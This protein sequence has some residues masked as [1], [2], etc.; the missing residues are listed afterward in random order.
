[1]R[2]S[3]SKDLSKV[4]AC[5]LLCG[6]AIAQEAVPRLEPA[7]CPFEGADGRDDVQCSY[8]VVPEN[9][10]APAGKILRL[11]VAVLKSTN[12]E[13][14]PD[15]LVFLSG[16][17]GGPSVRNSIARLNSPFWNRYRA[18]RDLVF[19]DQR[20]T[21]FSEPEFCPEMNFSV[22]TATFRGLSA[23]DRHT[24]VVD[25]V[26]DCRRKMLA[27]GID[28]AAYNTVTSAEDLADLRRALGYEQWNLFGGSYGT[29]LALTAVRDW[30]AGI[31]SVVL[32]STWPLNAPLGDSKARL[33][34]SLNLAFDQCA[35][36]AD[37]RAAFPN[38][39][40]DFF[41]ALNDFEAKPMT[42]Q[43]GD[44]DRFPDGRIVVDGNLLAW[45]MF[46]GFYDEGFVKVFPLVVRELGARNQD[47]LTA[48]ADG[49]VQ[50]LG[51]S[52]GLA[53]AVDC[54]DWITRVSREL[55]EADASRHPELKV[56]QAYAD[57]QGICNAW[58][59]FRADESDLQAVRS[60]VPILIFAGE[61]DPITPPA[62]GRLAA[63]SLPNSTFIEVP[64][65][66]HGAIPYRDCTI[67][68]M[69]EFLDRPSEKPDTT[70]VAGITPISFTTDVYMNAGVYRLAKQLE[71]PSTVRMI[72]S[73]VILLLLL[74]AVIAWPLAA[75]V[76]RVR[77]RALSMPAAARKARWL[78]ALTSLVG[79]AFIV[80]VGVLIA[81][82]AQ[83]NPYLI[84]FGVPANAR[85]LFFL[86]WLFMLGTAGVV[87]LA[88]VAWKRGW[89]SLPGRLHYSFI[90]CACV[91]LIAGIASLGLL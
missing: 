29:R 55:A 46:Q 83:E 31:R 24:L 64:G 32:D 40:E 76:R 7:D 14:R 27:Q 80:A 19:Y 5:T 9:R 4:L 38:L 33:A 13:P 50:E 57:E 66:S 53:Y 23:A 49:L 52:A 91:G 75:L 73:G 79:L 87:V 54:Y 42:L 18:E 51:V 85:P 25:S 62:F 56:W 35:G 6:S 65:A 71:Q 84:G 70:C 20:G 74:S 3:L 90:A 59:D 28:F 45:G 58:H 88:I 48:L 36:N 30:P 10:N 34:R 89:W 82:T 16:G 78:A 2:V 15:P 44:R 39:R 22:T 41:S 12:P 8:L 81:V 1:M 43:M 11:A 77:G 69:A 68:I 67:N 47:L 21:G 63:D 60:E 72:G 86:P 61:F 37:C 26:E 17:P